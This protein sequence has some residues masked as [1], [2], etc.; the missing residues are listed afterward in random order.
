MALNVDTYKTQNLEILLE[1]ADFAKFLA[2]ENFKHYDVRK[3][4]GRN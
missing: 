2:M 1:A 4:V 3:A